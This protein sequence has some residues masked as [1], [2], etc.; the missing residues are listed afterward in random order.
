MRV[1]VVLFLCVGVLLAELQIIKKEA[2]PEQK[3]FLLLSGIQGDEPG[4][5]NAAALIASRHYTITKGNVWVV[6]N[7]NQHSIFE[8]H[9]GIYGDM[10]RKFATLRDNDPEKKIVEEIKEL[11][12]N[13]RVEIVLHLH[14]GSGFYHDS[15]ISSLRNPKR[16]GQSS[17]IDQEQLDNVPHGDLNG[18]SQRI[19]TEINENLLN[20]LHRYRV[21][22]TNTAVQDKEQQL[23]LTFFTI[24]QGKAAFANEASKNL[25]LRE[26]VYYHLLAIEAMMHYLGIEFNRN[27]T[28]DPQT[29][30]AAL[31]DPSITI[32]FANK[33][34]LPI[35]RIKNHIT[36]F[37]MPKK[38]LAYHS[39]NPLVHLY[40]KKGTYS[41]KYG[42][43]TMAW[44]IPDY[45]ETDETLESVQMILDNS[46]QQVALGS[47]V[48]A[49]QS[50]SVPKV[51]DDVR[52][53]IIGFSRRNLVSEHDITIH[54]DQIESKFTLD[55]NG[56]LVRV[57]F[58]RG[59]KFSGMVIVD[60][61]Q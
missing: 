2:S 41:I 53:N 59:Q 42:N 16:W 57:E 21:R 12:K 5:F 46:S 17:I 18:I 20:D 58:Y 47:I 4:G 22:N 23:S 51:A 30:Q 14:D 26:R 10:N 61:E 52:V 27:F 45:F 39:T 32:A 28:L 34:S 44:L 31:D 43:K 19:I 40:Q 6:A 37:P 29:V 60:F 8:N 49:H 7:L 35:N 13:D 15:Y 24:N 36:Y 9:R 3:V 50:F 11:I 55:R 25:P 38:S 54:K 48:R 33:I 1:W 56:T